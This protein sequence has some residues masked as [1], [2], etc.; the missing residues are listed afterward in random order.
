M[1]RGNKTEDEPKELIDV[2]EDTLGEIHGDDDYDDTDKDADETELVTA[3]AEEEPEELETPKE[4][5][6]SE[7]PEEPE[8]PDDLDEPADTAERPQTAEPEPTTEEPAEQDAADDALAAKMSPRTRERFDHFRNEYKA[9]NDKYVQVT[10]ELQRV[11]EANQQLYGYLRESRVSPEQLSMLLNF[12][13]GINTGN[14][15]KIKPMWD[16]F[17]TMYQQAGVAM[18]DTRVAGQIP[19]PEDLQRDVD[20]L[21]I[22]AERAKE[23]AMLRTGSDMRQQLTAQQQQEQQVLQQQQDEVLSAQQAIDAWEKDMARKDPDF[24]AKQTELIAGSRELM[25]ELPPNMWLQAFQREYRLLSSAADKFNT[26]RKREMSQ[27]QPVRPIATSGAAVSDGP[28]KSF[29]DN[30]NR[31]LRALR[32]T[33]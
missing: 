25:S 1:P 9:A 27:N 8:E 26:Q 24:K 30:F 4:P 7:G 31:T 28:P 33:G 13:E 23:L 17:N 16:Q 29:D 32:S 22:T 19:L 15:S 20:N 3:S 18:G 11:D 21:D 2:L 6:K 5:E 12:A 10:E 14:F